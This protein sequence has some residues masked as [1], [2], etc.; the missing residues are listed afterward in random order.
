VRQRGARSGGR[1]RRH[2]RR[3]A[4]KP[5]WCL[6]SASERR[7]P[8]VTGTRPGRQTRARAARRPSSRVPRRGGR[9]R[10]A[11]GATR[12]AP[13]RQKAPRGLGRCTRL[14]RGAARALHRPAASLPALLLRVQPGHA[15]TQSHSST[16]PPRTRSF[17]PAPATAQ[18][19]PSRRRASSRQKS[20]R[21]R[22]SAP[23]WRPACTP[24][25][26][27][28]P[29]RRQPR[30]L[31]RSR[32]GTATCTSCALGRRLA[33]PRPRPTRLLRQPL[34]RTTLRWR[35]SSCGR[36]CCF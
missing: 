18:V 9:A 25:P 2:C 8:A 6:C 11:A 16:E 5:F 31:R 28:W 12:G 29:P 19:S 30:C 17:L 33:T 32:Y 27:R 13:T 26:A 10:C 35:W 7:R 22:S 34:P 15:K 1:Q 21:A 24:A 14:R 36:T 23:R 3:R 4:K 20:A